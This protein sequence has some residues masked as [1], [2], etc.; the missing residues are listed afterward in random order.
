MSAPVPAA[1]AGQSRAMSLAEAVANLAVGYVLA[2]LA[3]LLIFPVLGLQPTPMQTVK[4]GAAF[5][6]ISI[7]RSYALRRLFE[8]LRLRGPVR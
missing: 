3:Q 6:L 1:G 7:L 8:A 2:V 5:T 4:L